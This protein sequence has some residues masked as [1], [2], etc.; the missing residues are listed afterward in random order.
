MRTY[1][2]LA[3][4]LLFLV[5]SSAPRAEER[6]VNVAVFAG[7]SFYSMESAFD[8]VRGVLRT[9]TGY[10]GGK[11]EK[12]TYAQVS[13]GGTGHKEVVLV[14][15]DPKVVSYKMLLDVFWRVIDPLD[16]AGQFCDKGDQYIAAIFFGSDAERDAAISSKLAVQTELEEYVTTRI[17]PATTFYPAEDFHQ[18]FHL[19]NEYKYKFY[20][21]RCKRDEGLKKV[22]GRD[23][24]TEEDD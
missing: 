11:L 23:A 4:A 16:Q 1:A 13:N 10:M 9:T 19:R 7:G 24:I 21:K 22:W 3:L 8:K 18:D 15:Y 6:P 17:L 12:P 20:R 2:Y 5:P 14:T